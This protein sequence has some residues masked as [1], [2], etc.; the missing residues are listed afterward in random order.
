SGPPNEAQKAARVKLKGLIAATRDF[1]GVTGKITLD[2][3][4]NAVKP[5]VF[6]GIKDRAYTFVATVEP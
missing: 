2:E 4:R 6:L 1:P 3:H 5:A